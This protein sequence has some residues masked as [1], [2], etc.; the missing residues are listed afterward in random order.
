ML[1]Q[2]P[3]STNFPIHS[4]IHWEH[5]NCTMREQPIA[6]WSRFARS[7]IFN[8][9]WS[10]LLCL[11]LILVLICIPITI[12]QICVIL[13]YS[14]MNLLET[15]LIMN[16]YGIICQNLWLIIPKVV[17]HFGANWI[18]SDYKYNPYQWNKTFFYEDTH[19]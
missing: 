10:C 6:F 13:R 15:Y 16:F 14:Q 5:K 1:N 2:S 17:L 3:I 4:T 8:V 11:M 19:F 18:I 9:L 7:L 12:F